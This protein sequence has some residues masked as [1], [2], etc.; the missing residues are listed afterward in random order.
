[1]VIPPEEGGLKEVRNEGKNIVISNST[2][3]NILPLK[4]KK[5]SV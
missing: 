4:L 2:L 5:I 3:C 1:M